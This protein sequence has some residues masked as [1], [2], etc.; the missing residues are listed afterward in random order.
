M[1]QKT[2][3]MAFLTDHST[4]NLFFIGKSAFYFSM[5]SLLNS[6]GKP[7]FSSFIKNSFDLNMLLR[8]HYTFFGKYQMAYVSQLLE[9]WWQTSVYVKA[10]WFADILNSL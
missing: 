3:G 10:L 5:D 6:G 7:M 2:V 8:M 1:N 9:I 4:R